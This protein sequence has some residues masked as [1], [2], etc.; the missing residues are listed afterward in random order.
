MGTDKLDNIEVVNL[1]KNRRCDFLRI[2]LR[3]E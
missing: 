2:L 1:S 3:G